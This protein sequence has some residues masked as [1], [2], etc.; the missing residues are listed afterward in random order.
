MSETLDIRSTVDLAVRSPLTACLELIR[1]R[2]AILVLAATALGFLLGAS[3]LGTAWSTV[4][5]L[6]TLLGTVLVA[7]GANALNQVIESEHDARM[8]RTMNRPIPSGR[9]ERKA[10]LWLGLTMGLGGVAYLVAQVNTLA[11]ILGAL[12]LAGYVLVYTPMKRVTWRSVFIGAAP[13]ALPPAI[14]WAG[15]TGTL[16]MDAWIL[17]GIVFV[18]QMPHFAAIA[19][20]HRKDYQQAGYPMLPVL[21][22]TGRRTSRHL[23]AYSWLLLA[24]SVVPTWTGLVG[25]GYAISASVL[26]LA[27]LACGVYFV[28]Q[29][30]TRAARHHLMASIAYLPL[31]FVVMMI[32][33]AL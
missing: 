16:T 6:N 25:I 21:D 29:Q 13:G 14:G 18:W 2:I 4:A 32:D 30:T 7:A 8:T 15:A 9:L 24:I 20:L 22:P 33:R 1:V 3:A 10:A 28:R 11:G 19:W 31:L 23:M 17:F 5:L 26:G 27:F 12:S